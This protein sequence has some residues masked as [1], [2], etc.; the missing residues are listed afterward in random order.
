M[1]IKRE[2]EKQEKNSILQHS[3]GGTMNNTNKDQ[4]TIKILTGVIVVL[5]VLIVF[6]G[7]YFILSGQEGSSR[8]TTDLAV[9]Q[10]QDDINIPQRTKNTEYTEYN[11][12][13]KI[14]VDADYPN[15]YLTNPEANT[16]YMQ[17]DVYE[18]DKLL[19]ES[20][21]IEP[22][23]MENLDVYSMLDAGDHTL[24]YS[25]TTY[26]IDTRE[27]CMEGVRQEQDVNVVK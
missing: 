24:T 15:V 12:F 7:G 3:L 22:G 13:G 23:K 17:F 14:T 18:G 8:P 19:Y 6:V 21:L 4:K 1:D 5:L 26:D 9:S 25:I 2:F 10:N 27:L 16:V 20:G 11:G